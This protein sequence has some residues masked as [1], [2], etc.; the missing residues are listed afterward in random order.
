M[1]KKVLIIDDSPAQ[2]KLMQGLLEREGYSPVGLSDP[3]RVE[4]TVASVRPSVILLDVVMPGLSG[5]ELAERIVSLSPGLRVLYVSGY[6]DSNARPQSGAF[7][8][9]P[10]PAEALASKVREVLASENLARPN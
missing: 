6:M 2:I 4:E 1:L 3:K 7:L 5:P 10:F 9:K 8:Q